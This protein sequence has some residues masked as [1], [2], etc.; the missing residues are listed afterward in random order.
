MNAVRL[1]LRRIHRVSCVQVIMRSARQAS[2]WK[3]TW[4]ILA[5]SVLSCMLFSINALTACKDG[6]P[7]PCKTKDGK[8]GRR[9]CVNGRLTPCIPVQGQETP[10]VVDYSP[11]LT[12]IRYQT[13]GGCGTMSSLCI[14]DLL[15]EKEYPFSP[16]ASFRFAEYVYN[17]KKINQLDVLQQYGCCSEGNLPTNYDP[18]GAQVPTADNYREAHRYEIRSYSAVHDKPSVD[19]LKRYLR[20]YGPVFASGDAPGSPAHEHVFTIIGYDDNARQFTIVNSAGDEWGQNGTMKMPYS[21]ITHP[22]AK[23]E[24]GPRVDW[25][26]YVVNNLNQPLEPYVMRLDLHHSVARNHLKIDVR[27]EGMPAVTV[28]NRPHRKKVCESSK[29]L[30]LDV[31]LPAYASQKWPPGPGSNQWYV[32][33]TPDTQGTGQTGTVN[34]IGLVQRIRGQKPLVWIVGRNTP[35]R[36]GE[37]TTICIPAKK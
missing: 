6:G 12:Y 9:Y 14:L 10:R 35:I 31:A 22:P 23:V 36:C 13:G 19:Q 8:Q 32:T 3:G 24:D 37:E 11:Y 21:N 29:N 28:Y 27:A 15:K 2:R 17:D 34:S 20:S 33:I 18:P 1:G 4:A 26:R 30:K 25:V 5:V 7:Y 16:D